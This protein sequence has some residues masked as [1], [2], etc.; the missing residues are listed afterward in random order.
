MAVY[1]RWMV[2]AIWRGKGV[3]KGVEEMGGWSECE[4]RRRSFEKERVIVC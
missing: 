3:G 1:A 2:G 4:C